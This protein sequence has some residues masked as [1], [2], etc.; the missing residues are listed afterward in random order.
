MKVRVVQ[1]ASDDRPLWID[2]CLYSVEAWA[3]T[4]QFEYRFLDD[5]FFDI[6]PHWYRQKV[7]GRGPILADLARLLHLKAALEEGV[8]RVL[9]C[10]ADTLLL[11]QQWRPSLTPHTCFGEECWLQYDKTGRL[12]VRWQPH[13]AFM[14]F[15][16]T[17]PVLDFLRYATESIIRRA[18]PAHIAPQM[19]GPKLLKALHSIV[20]FDLE[21]SAGAVSP[22]LLDALLRADSQV[23]DV[24]RRRVKS[25]PKLV[26]LCASLLVDKA[27]DV[28]ELR[29]II[30]AQF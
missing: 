23:F 29:R 11:D 2:D 9:W 14:F 18:D 27:I 4:N 21:P 22:V 19:V 10:D 16:Q 26:N 28:H 6:L 5:H 20:D 7:A 13:N 25:P 8:D 1:S 15:S 12:E 3:A 30:G 24:F 17:S